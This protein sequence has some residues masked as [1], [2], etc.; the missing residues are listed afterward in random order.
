MILFF[1]AARL[2][3]VTFDPYMSSRPLAEALKRSPGGSLIVD[4]QY[5]AF[6]S[7]MFY[8]NRGALL[9]NGRK[10]N[11]DYG[12]NAPG[13]PDVFIDDKRFAM[14]WQDTQRYYL[15][16][17][18]PALVR[19]EKLVGKPALHKVAESGGKYLFTNR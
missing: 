17:Q 11:L 19:F 10:T 2:A 1:H 4:D 15:V 12:S 7:V 8:A 9:L 18:G 6:S 3:L 14:L 13:A 16:A 5:Y